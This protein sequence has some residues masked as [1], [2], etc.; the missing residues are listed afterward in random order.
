VF[1]TAKRLG[2]GLGERAG[3]LLGSYREPVMYNLA[4]AREIVKQV[5]RAENLKPPTSL[6]A[7]KDAYLTLWSRARNPQYWRDVLRSGEWTKLGIYALEAYGI[8]KIG[9]II[10]RRHLVGYKLD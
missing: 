5:Y 8:F 10:G 6:D 7:V 1:D 9:E 4:V 3:S 2:G